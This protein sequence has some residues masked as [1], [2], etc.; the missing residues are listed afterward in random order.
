MASNKPLTFASKQ[1][2]RALQTKNV[3][4][5]GPPKIP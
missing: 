2:L 3:E 1:K 5:T 4:V